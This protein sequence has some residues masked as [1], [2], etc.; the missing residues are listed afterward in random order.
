MNLKQEIAKARKEAYEQTPIIAKLRNTILD[1]V[2]R[3]KASIKFG[4]EQMSDSDQI[5]IRNYLEKEKINYRR[6]TE[7]RTV[8]KPIKYNPNAPD[9]LDQLRWHGYKTE[10]ETEEDVFLGF[11]IFFD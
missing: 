9:F 2:R 1:S 7:T 3:G 10:Y 4:D 5:A 11:G 6:L 8:I